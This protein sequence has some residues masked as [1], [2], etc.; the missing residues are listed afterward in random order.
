MAS[1]YE[2]G[3]IADQER[4]LLGTLANMFSPVRRP[5]RTPA[6][7]TY[8]EADG[9]LY[10]QYKSATYGEPEFGFEYMPAYRAISG[11][12]SDPEVA[13]DAAAAMPEAMRQMYNDQV[14]A[15]MDIAYGGSGELVDEDGRRISADATTIA[16]PLAPAGIAA[17]KAG[18]ATLGA[19]GGR[20]TPSEVAQ[21]ARQA[22]E[23]KNQSILT[24]A[25]Q[26]PGYFTFKQRVPFD[27]ID[28]I[29]EKAADLAPDLTFNPHDYVG[30]L[31]KNMPGD[32]SRAGENIVE[33]QG[34]RLTRPNRATGGYQ[35]PL[36]PTSQELELAWASNPQVM[37]GYYNSIQDAA[38]EGKGL[39]GVYSAMGG[40]SQDF[41]HHIADTLV[42]LT[43]QNAK[44]GKISKSAV[45][46]FD[47]KIKK[48]YPDFPGITSSKVEG[49]LYSDGKGKARKLVADTMD[50]AAAADAGFPYV[51]LARIAAAAPRLRNFAYDKTGH[52]N[53]TGARIVEFDPDQKIIHAGGNKPEWS[54]TYKSA[55][56]GSNRGG[57]EIDVPRIVSFPS[58]FENRRLI[59]G[60][61]KDDRKS[62][63]TS[64][65]VE[66][67][68]SE[69]ADNML[70]YRDE[71]KKGLLGY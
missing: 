70:L 43:K 14:L 19:M 54:K 33:V 61:P 21:I 48:V 59:G 10:P 65:V 52:T 5:V 58:F 20:L 45:K 16:A 15:G 6:E 57:L 17:A 32:I 41:S 69:I 66:P 62:F 53:P 7:T 67:L 2:Y 34:Q 39:L 11:L 22:G 36:E 51:P 49:Y 12:L 60:V 35:F 27:E 68:T 4:G 64:K 40:L 29:T 28:Y 55:A 24:G 31:M 23:A 46:D 71:Y 37:S 63:E 56:I 3:L 50:S 1:P 13:V 8:M 9:A 47:A 42:D 44:S 26:D 18:G 30:Y 25:P 38:K